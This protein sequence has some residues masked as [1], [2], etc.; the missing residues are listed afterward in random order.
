MYISAPCTLHEMSVCRVLPG[1]DTLIGGAPKKKKRYLN[2]SDLGSE[3]TGHFPTGKE[4]I[5]N[6]KLC[7]LIKLGHIWILHLLYGITY[8]NLSS[9]NHH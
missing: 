9:K 8:D 5:Y 7:A 2:C 1:C 4:A 6:M 3:N